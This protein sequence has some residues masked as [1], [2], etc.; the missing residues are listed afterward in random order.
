MIQLPIF[1]LNTYVGI[2]KSFQYF[3]DL[4]QDNLSDWIYIQIFNAVFSDVNHCN[5]LSSCSGSNDIF[6]EKAILNAS[7]IFHIYRIKSI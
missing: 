2:L 4:N 7:Q 1:I 5:F 6:V 3:S